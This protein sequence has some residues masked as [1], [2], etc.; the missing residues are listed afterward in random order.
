MILT[1]AIL[2]AMQMLNLVL[3]MVRE[4]MNQAMTSQT[5][6][7]TGDEK[8]TKE[9]G[10]VVKNSAFLV[11]MLLMDLVLVTVQDLSQIMKSQEVYCMKEDFSRLGQ[12]LNLHGQ[13]VKK[14]CTHSLQ[15]QVKKVKILGFVFC[16]L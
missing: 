8:G 5:S 12:T 1:L 7:G 6:S 14:V 2:V 10:M 9:K 4:M 13:C 3:V 11:D 15:C 16:R